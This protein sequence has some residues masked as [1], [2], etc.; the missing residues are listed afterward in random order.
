M[1][2]ILAIT[3]STNCTI[4]LIDCKTT[5]NAI[6][7]MKSIY[8]KLCKEKPYDYYNTYCDEDEGYAQIVDGLEQTELRIGSLSFT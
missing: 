1:G 8:N 5:E 2:T 3:S 4:K 7:K 6:A